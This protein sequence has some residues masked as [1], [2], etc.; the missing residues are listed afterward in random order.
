M[1]YPGIIPAYRLDITDEQNKPLH[2]TNLVAGMLSHKVLEGVLT[3]GKSYRWRV[4]ALDAS[5]RISVPDRSHSNWATFT[6]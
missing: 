3:V 4:Q 5:E 6:I 1:T 2:S